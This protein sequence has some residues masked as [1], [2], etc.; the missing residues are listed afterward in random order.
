MPVPLRALWRSDHG[1]SAAEFAL[2][3]PTFLLFLLGTIDVG[4]FIW[5][6]NESEKATQAGARLAVVSNTIPGGD[7]G[8]A[9]NDN[10]TPGLQCYSFALAS[11]VAQGSPVPKSLFPTITC[12]APGGTLACTPTSAPFS[13]V[14]AGNTAAQNAFGAIVA[15]VNELQPRADADNVVVTYEWSG[16]GYAGDPNGP[17]VSP[18]VTVSVR[19]LAFRPIFLAGF[20]TLGLPD[21]AYS[22]TLEDGQG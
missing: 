13:V 18:I 3:L 21:Q 17:D 15:R 2:V 1:A 5:A 9:A 8:C 11:N 10:R 14:T 20:G 6:V 16:L 7:I 19:G 12:S 4:R 22:L